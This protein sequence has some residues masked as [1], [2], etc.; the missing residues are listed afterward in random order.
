[1]GLSV[2]DSVTIARRLKR[3]LGLGRLEDSLVAA[4]V[5]TD[6]WWRFFAP[7]SRV[8]WAREAGKLYDNAVVAIAVNWI[9]SNWHE[10]PVVVGRTDGSGTFVRDPRHPLAAALDDP[11]PWYS[12]SELWSPTVLS[13]A[14]SG[15]AYW[16]I[17]SRNDGTPQF[18]YLPHFDVTPTG[19]GGGKLVGAY[20]HRSPDGTETVYPPERVVHFRWG[21]D[22]QDVRLGLSPLAAL[23]REVATDNLASTYSAAMLA[24][25][26]VPPLMLTPKGDLSLTT[27]QQASLKE[28]LRAV[29]SRDGQG[30]VA[31]MPVPFDVHASSAKPKEMDLGPLRSVPAQRVLAALG[32]SAMALDLPSDDKTY[33]NYR[34]AVESAWEKGVIPLKSLFCAQLQ[35]EARRW[36]ADPALE[37]RAD[38][39]G[40]RALQDDQDRLYARLSDAYRAGVLTRADVRSRLGLEVDE[41]RDSVFATDLFGANPR[42]AAFEAAGR[43]ARG[44]RAALE[45]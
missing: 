3:F 26:G 9:A 10:A 40:V 27:E 23:L 29:Y 15:N 12:G 30:R 13:M 21:L 45:G 31:V 37:V 6:A 44:R 14:V 33:S 8:D 35:R 34:E 39:S 42:L 41:A 22:P 4:P 20:R 1:M 17:G 28:S 7:A 32:L 11:N 19:G 38:W 43:R 2:P 18:G 5:Q 25:W 36:F 24:N 16:L